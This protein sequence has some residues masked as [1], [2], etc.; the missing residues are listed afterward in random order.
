MLKLSSTLIDK[1]SEG[2][3]R[4]QELWE[5]FKNSVNNV[6]EENIPS[7]SFRNNNTL[8][9]FKKKL[10]S[11]VRRKTRLYNQA[12]K[13]HQW[14]DYR[15]FQKH[16]KK[17]FKQTEVGYVNK[18]IQDGLD[19]NNTKPFWKYI[20]SKRQDNIGTP[21]LKKNGT[22]VNDDVGKSDIL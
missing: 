2:N 10:K 14:S 3:T 20:K 6:M 18:I 19:N 8:P 15:K 13:T 4:V 11:L 5:Y 9:W 17:E 16:C 21:P 1:S 12:K 7:K 22:L